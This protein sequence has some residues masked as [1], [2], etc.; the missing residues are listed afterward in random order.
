M[1]SAAA[2]TFDYRESRWLRAATSAM[3]LLA[4]LA[5]VLSGLPLAWKSVLAIAT[6]LLAGKTLHRLMRPAVLRAAWYADGHWRVRAADG[7]EHVATLLAASVRGPL[8]ALVLLAGPVGRVRLVLFPDNCDAGV[9]RSLR[10][11]LLH[12]NPVA[13]GA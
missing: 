1:K 5:V 6:C 10:V 8:I 7:S 9:R 3:V 11:R 2:I 12:A 13:A 4:I